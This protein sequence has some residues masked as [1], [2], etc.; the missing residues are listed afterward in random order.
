M[1]SGEVIA[2]DIPY[3]EYAS[4]QQ[5][6]REAFVKAFANI[7]GL[8]IYT[9]YITNFQ[10]SS[11][12]TTLIYFDT[13]LYGV[14]YDV[15]AANA[16]VGALFVNRTEGSP[17]IPA[18]V[19]AFH[20]NGLPAANA[21]YNNQL[22]PSTYVNSRI[23]PPINASQAG[24]WLHS[25]TGEVIA[26]DIQYTNYATRQQY[27]KEAFTAALADVLGLGYESVWVTDFQ[28]SAAG[29]VLLYFDV[30]LSA[31]SSTAIGTTFGVIQS[32]FTDCHPL[33]GNRL[34]CPAVATSPLV[35][36]L[37]QYF[38]DGILT[39]AYYNEQFPSSVG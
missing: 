14:D 20:A 1:D 12:G 13:I 27:Y 36:K 8:Q 19:N 10:V 34:G 18:L 29:T 23:T 22:T 16:A 17:A 2:L 21:F 31:T 30:E 32:L 9:V 5:Y 26:L 3:A 4:N 33:T 15:V 28:K 11:V 7:E 35:P 39:N 24:T 6:Y 38:G 25:D 37:K